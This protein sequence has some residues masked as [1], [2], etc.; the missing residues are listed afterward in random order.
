MKRIVIGADGGGTKTALCAVDMDSKS[1]LTQCVCEGI[2]LFSVGLDEALNTLCQGIKK[3]GI[4][5]PYAISLGDPSLDDSCDNSK[6][7]LMS[8]LQEIFPN[9][10]VFS[11]SDVFMALYAHTQGKEG[12]MLV[13]GTCSMGIAFTSPETP[14][15]DPEVITVGGRGF[16]TNDPGSAYSIAINGISL[17]LMAFDGM[18][19]ST[20][21]CQRLLDYFSLSDHKMLTELFNSDPPSHKE[22][23]G[24]AREVAYAAESQDRGA[25]SVLQRATEDL[26]LHAVSLLRALPGDKRDLAL[27]GSVLKN[28][29]FVRQGLLKALQ[30]DFPEAKLSLL[31]KSPQWGAA[32][33]AINKIGEAK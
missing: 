28:N 18:A 27:S 23:S 8:A 16:P 33:Y 3:L 13:S 19:S 4:A 30:K 2:N 1:I 32:I 12:A 24:F 29:T 9:T 15:K 17:A 21:L 25:M 10:L 14:D 5:T 6:A 31:D 22:L 11:K 7:P 20:E 26:R